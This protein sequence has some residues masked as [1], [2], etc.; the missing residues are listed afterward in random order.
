MTE[1]NWPLVGPLDDSGAFVA[2]ALSGFG[3]MGACAAGALCADWVCGGS[4][5]Q[6]A[7]SISL[8]RYQDPVLLRKMAQSND[9]GLL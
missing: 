1:E 4:L 3:S 6:Y 2:G 9:I 5:P 8:A 7:H